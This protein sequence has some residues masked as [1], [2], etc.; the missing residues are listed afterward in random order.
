[1]SV[2]IKIYQNKLINEVLAASC[3][4]DVKNGINDTF[5]GLKKQNVADDQV[6]VLVDDTLKEL[7]NLNQRKLSYD[8][9]ANIITAKLHLKQL[10]LQM[11]NVIN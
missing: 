8:Q 2:S 11:M 5:F 4:R 3:F 10:Q 9:H 7:K 6:L 1:M